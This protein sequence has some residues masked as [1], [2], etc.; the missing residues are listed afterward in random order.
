M[1]FNANE[2]VFSPL[3]DSICF[4]DRHCYGKCSN[5]NTPLRS[6]CIWR[7]EDNLQRERGFLARDATY[8]ACS[9]L[10]M[11]LKT[12]GAL[13][14]CGLF[15][16]RYISSC[17]RGSLLLTFVKLWLYYLIIVIGDRRENRKGCKTLKTKQKRGVNV[18]ISRF[19][20]PP[21]F[22]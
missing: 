15:S 1:V 7:R 12:R 6:D 13:F 20:I 18:E 17:G 9:F 5:L 22:S 19:L 2:L 14:V 8:R 4:H 11:L 21:C 10:R 3:R 16:P